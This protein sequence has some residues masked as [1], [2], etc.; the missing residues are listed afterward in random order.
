[1]ATL[2]TIDDIFPIKI[3]LKHFKMAI[4]KILESILTLIHNAIK[5]KN[6][7]K[8]KKTNI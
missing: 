6:H 8:V 7:F 5:V 2:I 1:M 4:K 3:C